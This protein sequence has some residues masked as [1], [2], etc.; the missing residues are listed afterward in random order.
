[1]KDLINKL[2]IRTLLE[3]LIPE[4]LVGKVPLLGTVI[5][6]S[7]Y[8]A[9]ALAALLVA[10]VVTSRGGGGATSGNIRQSDFNG[11]WVGTLHTYI[12]N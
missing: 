7:N 2:P 9:L 11:T 12:V 4:A 1:M 6:Y 8:I 5:S 10:N 3:K